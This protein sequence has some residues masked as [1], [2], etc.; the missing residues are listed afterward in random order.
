MFLLSIGNHNQTIEK[1]FNEELLSK[2]FTGVSLLGHEWEDFLSHKTGS[3]QQTN[4][5]DKD[6]LEH[7]RHD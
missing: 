5:R 4:A 2:N 7:K 6:W 3:Q 1:I